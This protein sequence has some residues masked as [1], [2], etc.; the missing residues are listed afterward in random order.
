[1]RHWTLKDIVAAAVCYV[2]GAVFFVLFL[3][4]C[5]GGG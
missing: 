1:M 5:F 2:L 4:A 3:L